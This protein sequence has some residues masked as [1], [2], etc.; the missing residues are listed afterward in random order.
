MSAS[1]KTSENLRLIQVTDPHL[2][3][4]S[5]KSLRGVDTDL[6]LQKVLGR[7]GQDRQ[8]DVLLLSGD[9]VQ[10]ESRE[11]YQRLKQYVDTL[12]LPTFSI[13]GNHDDPEIM[14]QVLAGSKSQVGGHAIIHNW[15]LIFV[16][17]FLKGSAAGRISESE[18]QRLS[19][20]LDNNSDK[21]VLIC[22]HHHPV[23]IGSRWLDGVGLENST[24][25]WNIVDEYSNVRCIIWGHVHQE[26]DSLRNGAR[27]LST[28]STCAQFRPGSD[29][30]EID[31][32]PPA[33]RWIQLTDDGDVTSQT[34]WIDD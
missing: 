6:S 12:G 13:P 31:T 32:R 3:A 1:S 27:L 33:Y 22:L 8:A 5:G 17:S 2:F 4:S 28:P 21:Y 25:F 15:C 9:L 7:V 10:D 23:E 14:E 19:N 18:L 16:S 24:A 30:F 20:V 11:G 34:V 26:H 29:D